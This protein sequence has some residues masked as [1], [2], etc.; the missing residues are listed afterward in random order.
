MS[1]ITLISDWK[2]NDFYVAVMKGRILGLY[3]QATIVD[4]SHQVDAFSI[5]EAA[6]IIKVSYSSFPKGSVHII[7]VNLENQLKQEEIIAKYDGHYFIC[8]NDGLLSLVFDHEPD[9]IISLENDHYPK[10]YFGFRYNSFPAFTKYAHAAIHALQS[11]DINELG[12]PVPDFIRLMDFMPQIEGSAITG[13]V[14]YIDTYQ[15]AITNISHDLFVQIGKG[16]SFNIMLESMYHKLNKINTSYNETT[17]G[18]LLAIFNSLGLL[19]IAQKNGRAAEMLNLDIHSSI[20]I[21][22]L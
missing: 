22:F 11:K 16:R 9:Q 18:E 2:Q 14:V 7:A 4:I 8:S 17:D 5:T 21:K 10:E 20:R 12:R 15:N 19:E 6:F 1:V 3:P 13:S